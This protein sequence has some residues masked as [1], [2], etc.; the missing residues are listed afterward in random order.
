MI[1]QKGLGKLQAVVRGE[2]SYLKAAVYGANDGIITT[3]AVVA[4]A[5]GAGLPASVVIVLGGANVVAD[6]ISMGLGD[7]LG[8]RSERRITTAKARPDN[9]IPSWHTGAITVV[10]FLLAGTLPL[11]PFY[12]ELMGLSLASAN[13]FLWSAVWTGIGLFSVGS[14]R[15]LITSG[16]WLRNGLEMLSIGAIAAFTAYGLGALIENFFIM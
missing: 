7:F 2:P 1:L 9:S 14:L 12:L 11:M 6:G 5:A 15:T 16:S 3:F 13:R 8:E 4:G 10:F